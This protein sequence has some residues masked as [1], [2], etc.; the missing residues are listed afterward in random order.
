MSIQTA[1]NRVVKSNALIT[2]NS[3]S[4]E[5]TRNVNNNQ[6]A[7]PMYRFGVRDRHTDRLSGQRSQAV[8]SQE[9]EATLGGFYK[10]GNVVG[11]EVG[12]MLRREDGA[13]FDAALLACGDHEIVGVG[14]RINAEYGIA[15][16]RIRG[17]V[18]FTREGAF[19][20][21]LETFTGF[22]GR[23]EAGAEGRVLGVGTQ[24]EVG[25]DGWAGGRS[26]AEFTTGPHGGRV[27]I[28]HLTGSGVG[29]DV[30]V[31]G[32]GSQVTVGGDLYSGVGGKLGA[33]A[34]YED[35]KIK[36]G[37]EVGFAL[38]VG[39]GIDGHLAIDLEQAGK[40]RDRAA[41]TAFA[42]GNEFLRDTGLDQVP[43]AVNEAIEA[44]T[45]TANNVVDTVVDAVSSGASAAQ[46]AAEDAGEA[47]S[48]FIDD[49][50]PF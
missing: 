21:K 37:G 45:E 1:T 33:E 30:S 22:E 11:G 32:S 5:R 26:K 14:G 24:V 25:V 40:D 46:D 20:A 49:I 16:P 7:E 41:K 17:E 31:G 35:G 3:A 13:G 12:L 34:I 38:G 50:N 47:V 10:N 9:H 48:G 43:D 42:I 23:L 8:F 4:L 18:G 2:N 36:V 27:H 29:G 15:A 28:E 44:G 39:L 19:T 6:P